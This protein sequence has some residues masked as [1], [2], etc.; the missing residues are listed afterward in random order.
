MKLGLLLPLLMFMMLGCAGTDTAAPAWSGAKSDG[1]PT[2][3]LEFTQMADF[4]IRWRG[5]IGESGANLLQPALTD[6]A[7]YGVSGD[8][9]FTRLNPNTGKQQWR[10]GVG[11]GIS[12]GIT[13]SGQGLL[14][15]GGEKGD[16][17]AYGEGGKLIWQAKV[18][19]EVLN[20]SDVVDG[21]ILVRSGDGSIAALKVQD[22]KREWLY[23]RSTPALVIRSHAG[24]AIQREVAYAGFAGGKLAAI[25]IKDGSVLWEV[26][27]S[28]PR[29]S[30][31]LE[32][33]SDITSTPVVDDEQVCAIAFQGRVACF[34]V[35][36]GT[37]LWNREISSDKGMFLLRRV[38]YLTDVNGMVIALDKSSGSTVWKNDRLAYRGVS[39]PYVSGDFV[40]V[41]DFEGYLHALNR[42]DGSF[43]ARIKLDDSAIRSNIL[44]ADDELIVQTQGGYLYSLSLQK[45]KVDSASSE[46][47]REPSPYSLVPGR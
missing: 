21:M 35:A 30:T 5:I 1:T 45:P 8:R 46:K 32:R 20:I 40:L 47:I 9:I 39:T 19:S 27:V 36:R 31:E 25:S 17:R 37:P 11:I 18:T 2:K 38:L 22:G 13:S 43:V 15:I 3:L 33:I 23:E 6:T 28:Q 29:G 14:F 34:D 44:Q 10:I 26:A 7:V 12:G 41:G 16:V 42:E 24:L 4:K